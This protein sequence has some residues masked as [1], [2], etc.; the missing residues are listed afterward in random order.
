MPFASS[1][2]KCRPCSPTW[3]EHVLAE[4]ADVI[5]VGRT[6]AGEESFASAARAQADMLIVS[7]PGGCI[8][9]LLANPQIGIL[10]ISSNGL[11]AEIT[12]IE[13]RRVTVDRASLGDL[14]ER[15]RHQREVR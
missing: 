9:D 14:L 1:S 4:I 5:I 12:R 8:G 15:F 6:L 11:E 2:E 7:E 3:V 13:Q 10:A